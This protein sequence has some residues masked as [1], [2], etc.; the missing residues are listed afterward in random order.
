M[1]VYQKKECLT[2]SKK[3]RGQKKKR[4]NKTSKLHLETGVLQLEVG[5]SRIQLIIVR[6]HFGE[7]KGLRMDQSKSKTGKPQQSVHPE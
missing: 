2:D 7:L 4:K 6:V 3:K 1:R 5:D